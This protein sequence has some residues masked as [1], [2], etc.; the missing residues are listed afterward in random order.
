MTTHWGVEELAA[1]LA[2]GRGEFAK[3]VFVDAAQHV[4]GPAGG[5]AEGDRGDEVH[6]LAEAGL[7]ER[8][9]AVV[10]GEHAAERGVL[11][12]DGHHGVVDDLAD[13]GVL[14]AGL[15]AS[16]AGPAGLFG[17]PEDVVHQVFVPLLRVCLGVP[18]ELGAVLFEGVGDVFEE[19]QAEDDVFVFRGVH[20]AAQAVGGG[21]ELVLEAEVGAGA[22]AVGGFPPGAGA[23]AAPADRRLLGRRCGFGLRWHRGLRSGLEQGTELFQGDGARLG[24]PTLP[25]GY[26]RLGHAGFPGELRLAQAGRGAAVTNPL[27]GL[28]GEKPSGGERGCGAEA[29]VRV[30]EHGRILA[31]RP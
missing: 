24:D 19:D 21:P 29:G 28:H 22:V 2:F 12:F 7:V 10:L 23:G 30:P 9:P 25:L 18:L 27:C 14:G 16:R 20:V 26:D 15:D 13:G 5:V 6:E 17:D 8:R 3:E 11:P 31:S 1:A 4:L